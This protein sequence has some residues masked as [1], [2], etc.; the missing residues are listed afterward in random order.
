MPAAWPKDQ[1]EYLE[2]KW[3]TVS[4]KF[5]AKQLGKSVN[6]VKLKA[7]R[8]GLGRNYFSYDGIT[9]HQ[10]ALAINTDYKILKNWIDKY[11]F[12]AKKK[13]FANKKQ[14]SVVRYEDFWGW[15]EQHKHLLN[16][17]RIEP[18][19]LGPEPEW[20]KEKRKAD[21]LKDNKGCRPW[22]KEDDRLLI[23]M[24]KAYRYT[25]PEIAKSLRRSEGAVKRRLHDLNI[26]A[27][28][29]RLSNHVKYTE[30]EIEQL[31]ELFHKGYSIDAIAH[32]LG[33]SGLG[34]RGKLERMGYKNLDWK[35]GSLH[36]SAEQTRAGADRFDSPAAAENIEVARDIECVSGSKR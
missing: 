31:L 5:M 2:E 4:L 20:V 35:V 19:I 25:Y 26:K 16:L 33:K 7:A 6:A 30:Q 27:R 15:A 9:I 36:E 10:L 23:S 18:N 14:I 32:K 24:V 17:T 34:V 13:I 28:P 11:G 29:V 1:V 3:G 12:P 8:L 21:Q 22:T